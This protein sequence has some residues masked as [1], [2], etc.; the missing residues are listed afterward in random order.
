MINCDR[1]HQTGRTY[2]HIF[3]ARYRYRYRYRYRMAGSER[4]TSIAIAIPIAIA[5]TR[6][7]PDV[8]PRFVGPKGPL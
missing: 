8:I 6:L 3:A 5:I 2:V 7:L 1:Y 4:C